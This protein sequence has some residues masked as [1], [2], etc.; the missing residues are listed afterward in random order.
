VDF[1]GEAPAAARAALV[2]F[3]GEDPAPPGRA[4]IVGKIS[5]PVAS[6][7]D[8]NLEPPFFPEIPT[9]ENSEPARGFSSELTMIGTRTNAAVSE[10]L[11]TTAMFAEV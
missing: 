4:V 10:R 11:N 3:A 5:A 2:D 9:G 8:K 1:K 7:D 6:R